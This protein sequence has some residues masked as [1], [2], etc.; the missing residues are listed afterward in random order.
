MNSLIQELSSCRVLLKT[1]ATPMAHIVRFNLKRKRKEPVRKPIWE[2]IAPSKLFRIRH[3]PELSDQEQQQRTH[4]EETY[5]T[6][7]RSIQLYFREQFYSPTLSSGG[8]SA[9]QV[10]NE[11]LDQMALIEENDR[12]NQRVAR[13]RKERVTR[14]EQLVAQKMLVQHLDHNEELRQKARQI[15]QTVRQEI[16]RSKTY[17]THTT[18]EAAIE[19]ALTHSVSYDFAIDTDGRIYSEQALHPY[20]LRPSAVPESSSNIQ[21]MSETESSPQRLEPKDVY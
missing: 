1:S 13:M 8:L 7:M 12:E 11:E 9:E 4:M 5:A 10:R 14:M 17:I 15:D 19:E 21:E 3:R 20:A 2:P 18:L 16:K 6:A